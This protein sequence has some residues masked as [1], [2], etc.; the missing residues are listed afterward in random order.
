[1]NGDY[2]WSYLN[3]KQKNP[4][5]PSKA[6]YKRNKDGVRGRAPGAVRAFDIMDAKQILQFTKD[7]LTFLSSNHSDKLQLRSLSESNSAIKDFPGDDGLRRS[8][9]NMLRNSAQP[10][11]E[12]FNDILDNQISN[13]LY[14]NN[15][16]GGANSLFNTGNK[17]QDDFMNIMHGVLQDDKNL[18]QDAIKVA[19]GG[20]L[21]GDL[22]DMISLS[23][24]SHNPDLNAA[25]AGGKKKDLRHNRK[26]QEFILAEDEDVFSE[27]PKRAQHLRMHT[28]AIKED[29]Q[30]KIDVLNFQ[31]K[32][33]GPLK[34]PEADFLQSL[35]DLNLNTKANKEDIFD[36]FLVDLFSNNLKLDL[37]KMGLGNLKDTAMSLDKSLMLT[38]AKRQSMEKL[39]LT[40]SHRGAFSGLQV[41]DGSAAGPSG[42]EFSNELGLRGASEF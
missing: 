30:Q 23:L 19:Q 27:D 8:D 26:F 6:K 33:A 29:L 12:N 25:A 3:R 38:D 32:K 35:G 24:E 20:D 36:D 5:E 13:F 21:F 14:D 42:H 16:V 39:M 28:Q 31:A 18:L 11:D 1:M 9:A 2:A 41:R 4:E 15:G 10:E 37:K 40:E 22:N 7:R 17:N 34:R